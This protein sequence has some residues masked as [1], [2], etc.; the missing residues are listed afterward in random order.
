MI[1]DI[2]WLCSSDDSVR[3]VRLGLKAAITGPCGRFF[4]MMKGELIAG[5]VSENENLKFN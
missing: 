1:D 2:F 3:L 4:L 5:L